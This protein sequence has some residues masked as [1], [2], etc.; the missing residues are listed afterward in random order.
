MW[1][2]SFSGLITL[3]APKC[4]SLIPCYR[5]LSSAW[6]IRFVPGGQYMQQEKMYVISLQI[7][8]FFPE[9]F[10]FVS[11]KDAFNLRMWK[12]FFLNLFLCLKIIVNH[13]RPDYSYLRISWTCRV[14]VL[15]IIKLTFF[16]IIM[17][18]TMRMWSTSCTRK[19]VC[20]ERS[21]CT[22]S[23]WEYACVGFCCYCG[24]SW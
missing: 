14:S 24:C 5:E 19:G 18:K 4:R 23:C 11:F 16:Q 1:C 6:H 8:Y 13:V 22:R 21:Y 9:D 20:W 2:K 15:E 10:W 17:Y 3:V 7:I 12:G